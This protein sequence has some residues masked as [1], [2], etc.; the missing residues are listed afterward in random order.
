M[1]RSVALWVACTLATCFSANAEL[2]NLVTNPG[3]LEIGGKRYVFTKKGG[4]V[5]F[6]AST[7]SSV[8]HLS[9]TFQNGSPGTASANGPHS[10]LYG[11]SAIGKVSEVR[12]TTERQVNG[13]TCRTSNKRTCA[14]VIPEL[15]F[16]RG[17]WKVVDALVPHKDVR[18]GVITGDTVDFRAKF[19]SGATPTNSDISW[20]GEKTGTGPT[21]NISFTG[22]GNKTVKLKVNGTETNVATVTVANPTGPGENQWVISHPLR[23]TTVHALRDEARAWGVGHNNIGDARRHAY[24]NAIMVADW[25]VADAEGLATAHEVTGL[26]NGGAHNETVMDLENNATGR[27]LSSAGASRASLQAAVT[28]AGSSGNLVILD[29]TGNTNEVGLLKPSNQ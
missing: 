26:G 22:T 24:W 13:Q 6:Q 1:K 7:H 11:E 9:W 18:I 8:Y 21:I 19:P 4:T 12:F 29:N 10:I 2:L 3:Y 17:T 28:S 25:N 27:G 23:W 5:S 20:E 16:S 14:V 15:E